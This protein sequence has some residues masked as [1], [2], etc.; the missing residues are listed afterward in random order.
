MGQAIREF[1][2]AQYW[3]CHETLEELWLPEGYPRRLFYHGLIKAA[4]GLLHLERHNRHGGTAKLRDARYALTPFSPRFMGVEIGNLLTDISKR[5][6]YCQDA[7]VVDWYAIDQLSPV[8]IHF[9]KSY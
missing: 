1:N 8:Y 2:R 3:Q 7:E 4:V 6:V 5:L 9:E